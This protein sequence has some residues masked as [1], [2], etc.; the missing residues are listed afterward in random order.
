MLIF[1]GLGNS[2]GYGKKNK[3]I[4]SPEPNGTG[5]SRETTVA[6]RMVEAPKFK[7]VN[8]PQAQ[9]IKIELRKGALWMVVTWSVSAAVQCANWRTAILK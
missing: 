4:T 3:A 7:Q 8:R 9:E 1:S 5:I 2:D 6:R